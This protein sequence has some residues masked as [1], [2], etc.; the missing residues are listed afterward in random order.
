MPFRT[1][2]TLQSWVDEFNEREHPGLSSIR[3]I[4]QDGADGADTGL[5]AVRI[6]DSP[7]EIVIEPPTPTTTPEWT[8]TFEPREQP[9]TLGAAAVAKIADEVS[10]LAELCTFLQMKS[11]DFLARLHAS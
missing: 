3:V 2:A 6:P 9:V 7:V 4:P 8:I 1:I 10:A 5:V 11:D